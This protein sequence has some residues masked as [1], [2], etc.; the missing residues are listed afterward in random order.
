MSEVVQ[1]RATLTWEAAQ[2]ELGD[3][4]ELKWPVGVLWGL[5]VQLLAALRAW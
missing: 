2:L 1:N 5:W 3:E 4:P